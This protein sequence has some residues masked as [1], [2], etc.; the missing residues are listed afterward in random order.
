MKNRVEKLIEEVK[1]MLRDAIS[2]LA[3]M[4]IIDALQRLGVDYHFE[5]EI[6]Q[7]LH[8]IYNKPVKSDDLHTVSLQFRLLRQNRYNVSSGTYTQGLL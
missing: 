7:E 4:H 5:Q 6:G 3:K 8:Q 1:L 2:P